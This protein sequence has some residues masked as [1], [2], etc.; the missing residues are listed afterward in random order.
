MAISHRLHRIP[1]ALMAAAVALMGAACSTAPLTDTGADLTSFPA[2]SWPS[3]LNDAGR[4]ACTAART[5]VNCTDANGGGSMCLS[6]DSLT[7][8]GTAAGATCQD[9]CAPNQYAVSC[10]QVGP[11]SG[12]WTPPAN[13]SPGLFTPAGIAFYCCTCQ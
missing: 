8:Q 3:A 11:N 13:C 6:N 4:G 7:C 2:C 9:K 12:D 1:I 5:L 10:G